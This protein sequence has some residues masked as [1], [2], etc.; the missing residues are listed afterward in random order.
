MAVRDRLN[1]A[2]S[3]RQ[4]LFAVLLVAIAAVL[5]GGSQLLIGPNTATAGYLTMLFLLSVVRAHSWRARLF[6]AGWSLAVALLGYAVGGMSVW[7]ALAALVVVSLVQGF[8]T[9]GEASMLTRS[10]VNL[11]AFASL[12]ESGA[13]VW[14]ALLGF[15]IGAGVILAF[16][17]H[18]KVRTTEL[19]TSTSLGERLGYGVGTAA[20]SLLIVVGADLL[21]FPYVGWAL[22]SFAIILSFDTGARRS[23]AYLRMAG[24]AIGA[25]LSV[26]IAALPEPIPV[27]MA[28]ICLVLCVAYVNSGNYAMF[29]LFLTPAVLLTT[30]SEDPLWLIGVYRLEAVLFATGIALLCSV[31]VQLVL[32]A[33]QRSAAPAEREKPISGE[34][35]QQSSA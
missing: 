19:V 30:A 14:Q 12:S 5:L 3:P 29:V 33:I 11:L 21:G 6:S 10:P 16:A 25:V 20:G 31:G 27:V 13:E 24:S 18:T 32:H 8:V 9:V 35:Q 17:A 7:A 23:R 34:N 2:L 26:L 15:V 1:L 4:I 22:L 28:V